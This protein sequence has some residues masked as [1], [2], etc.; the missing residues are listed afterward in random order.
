MERLEARVKQA[1][2]ALADAESEA[3]A[4]LAEILK[5]WSVLF[6]RRM[7]AAGPQW[8]HA[9]IA[10]EGFTPVVNGESFDQVSVAGSTLALVELNAL[11]S[12]RELGREVPGS[13]VPGLLVVD[14]ALTGLSDAPADVRVR[15]YLLDLFA[16]TAA[17][18]GPLSQIVTASQEAIGGVPGARTI[19]LSKTDPYIPGLVLADATVA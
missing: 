17:G 19:A 1:A 10:E 4:R 3:R 18:D 12:L 14:A 7:A 13:S 15:Q 16:Q 6:A 11:V 5:T 8:R 9:H 2:Q